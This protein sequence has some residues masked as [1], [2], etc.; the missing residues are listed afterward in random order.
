M[1]K[2]LSVQIGD[3]FQNIQYGV[4]FLRKRQELSLVSPAEEIRWLHMLLYENEV[5]Y[6][7]ASNKVIIPELL[8][9]APLF[10]IG[11]PNSVNLGGIGVR[12]SEAV[13]QGVV[14]HGLLFD[15]S[16]ML[17]YPTSNTNS[18]SSSFVARSLFA[19]PLQALQSATQCLAENYAQMGIDTPNY[20][21]K[22]RHMSVL[23]VSALQQA[24]VTL[25]DIL[26]ME[27]GVIL[28]AMETYDPQALFYLSYAQSL[29]VQRTIKQRDIDRTVGQRLLSEER[30]KATLSQMPSFAHFYFCSD[31]GHSESQCKGAI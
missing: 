12:M 30:L 1:Y 22:C 14:G 2:D 7:T 11:F 13:I 16:G 23:D 26:E 29:C 25:E 17:Q 28:P 21:H 24:Y 6:S 18:N 8:L 27:D 4:S 9:Q 5:S 20:L 10:H 3:F 15:T 19:Q 31:S